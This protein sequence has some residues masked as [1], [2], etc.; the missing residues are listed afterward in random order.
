MANT[1]SVPLQGGMGAD[2]AA[3]GGDT[4]GWEGIWKAGLGQG[5]V[6]LVIHPF[7]CMHAAD[8]F[9]VLPSASFKAKLVHSHA[10]SYCMRSV[11]GRTLELPPSACLRVGP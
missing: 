11:I 8:D 9:P 6:R 3:A 10:P 1:P 7:T 2:L 4:H 5:E